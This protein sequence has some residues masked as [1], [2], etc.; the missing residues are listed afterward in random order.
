MDGALQ[1]KHQPYPPKI[2]LE[3][4]GVTDGD[5]YIFLDPAFERVF[6]DFLDDIERNPIRN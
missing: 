4:Y 2:F 1:E 5:G 3:G 6:L